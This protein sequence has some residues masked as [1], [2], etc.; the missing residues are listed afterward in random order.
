MMMG[1]PFNSRNCFG[2]EPPNRVPLPPATIIAT[3]MRLAFGVR[4]AGHGWS[5]LYFAQWAAAPLA[6]AAIFGF[7]ANL[8][9]DHFTG[10]GLQDAGDGNVRVLSNQAPR[11]VDH[12][13]GSVVE[14]GHALVVF[15][16]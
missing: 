3:F 14:I 6:G 2:L 4:N 1:V 11:I 16:A 9:E 15:F 7:V 8:A 13:H 10:G 5:C 12:D